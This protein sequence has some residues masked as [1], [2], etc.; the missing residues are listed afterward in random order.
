[1][2]GIIRVCLEN[3][4]KGRQAVSK[5]QKVKGTVQKTSKRRVPHCEYTGQNQL[6]F[7]GFGTS[8]DNSRTLGPQFPH[9]PMI[10]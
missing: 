8:F 6:S 4:K 7:T 1:M 2:K 10:I 5:I 3:K 9:S